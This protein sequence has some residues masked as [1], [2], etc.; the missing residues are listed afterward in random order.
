MVSKEEQ[1]P[2]RLR[3]MAG[4]E[5]SHT[6]VILQWNML[7]SI[8]T[9]ALNQLNQVE[10]NFHTRVLDSCCFMQ[11]NYLLSLKRNK[12][13]FKTLLWIS[14]TVSCYKMLLLEWR[15]IFM[16]LS[17]SFCPWTPEI[18]KH[19]KSHFC[20][21]TSAFVSFLSGNKCS[22]LFEWVV[23]CFLSFEFNK[24]DICIITDI[25]LDFW[26]LVVLPVPDE[27]PNQCLVN[28]FDELP[29]RW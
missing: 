3:C 26:L 7:L 20:T 4:D 25:P 24:P 18:I 5:L 13:K 16:L 6:N 10:H 22:F 15:H 1:Q 2:L 8:H 11:L 27:E 23:K 21:L 28:L 9:P 14:R 12:K 29:P 19:P 17:G